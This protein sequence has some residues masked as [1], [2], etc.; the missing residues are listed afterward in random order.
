MLFLIEEKSPRRDESD[1]E[2]PRVERTPVSHPQ[3]MPVFPGMDPAVLKVPGLPKS[4]LHASAPSC[5]PFLVS[6]HSKQCLLFFSLPSFPSCLS[7]IN[8]P[9]SLSPF[10]LLTRLTSSASICH[11]S[12]G[13]AEARDIMSSFSQSFSHCLKIPVT[14]AMCLWTL[15]SQALRHCADAGVS[16]LGHPLRGGCRS[17]TSQSHTSGLDHPS[18]L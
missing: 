12:A 16:L 17:L 13:M 14:P 5:P 7:V 2:P 3:R 9:A 15:V 11:P 18:A 4:S 10:R 6:V 1:E 8:Q